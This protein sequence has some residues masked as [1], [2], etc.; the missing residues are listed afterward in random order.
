MGL[1]VSKEEVAKAEKSK[2]VEE[3]IEGDEEAYAAS[4]TG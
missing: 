2:D 3:I 4:L 1:T